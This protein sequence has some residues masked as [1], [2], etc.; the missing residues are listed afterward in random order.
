MY[1]NTGCCVA[2][3]CFV[4]IFAYADD[5]VLLA[6]SWQAM[7]T[8]IAILEKA[9]SGINMSVN[10]SKIVCMVFSPL[11]K[12][13]VVSDFFPPLKLSR[14]NLSYRR[15]PCKTSY[16]HETKFYRRDKKRSGVVVIHIYLL[17]FKYRFLN[18]LLIS[19]L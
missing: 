7:Q 4:N 18:Q 2:A 6:P 10:L 14:R 1:S 13:N 11:N 16:V 5:P 12:R 15:R 19:M 9:A 17:I 3:G 8:L